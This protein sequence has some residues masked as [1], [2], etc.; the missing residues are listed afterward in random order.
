MYP[1]NYYF[2]FLGKT[3]LPPNYLLY[4]MKKN[5]LF[6]F[7]ILCYAFSYAQ[8]GMDKI[9][10]KLHDDSFWQ[11]PANLET[12]PIRNTTSILGF[13]VK[14]T[15]TVY[16]TG[17]NDA[18]L[19]ANGISFTPGNFRALPVEDILFAP[20]GQPV[21]GNVYFAFPADMDG[22]PSQAL[23]PPFTFPDYKVSI[24]LVFGPKGMDIGTVVTNIP[25]TTFLTFDI[26]NEIQI[27]SINDAIPDIVISQE[28]MTGSND[29]KDEIWFEDGNGNMIGH[30]I[31][32]FIANNTTY[33]QLGQTF[34][35]FYKL[36]NGTP[37][38]NVNSSRY[39]KMFSVKLSDF[40]ITTLNYTQVK[41]LKYKFNGSSDPGVIAYNESSFRI[42][43]LEAVD[44][45]ATTDRETPV[46]INI[47]DN[48]QY[49]STDPPVITF[50][51]SPAHGTI[52]LSG[53]QVIY[54]PDIN[55]PG[56]TVTFNY[57]I[58]DSYGC[59]EA[60]VTITIENV[61]RK[62]PNL[63][64]ADSYTK[65]GITTLNGVQNT[66]P[67]A[68]IPNGFL[69]LESLDKGMVIS[70]TTSASITNPVEGMIIYDTS[71]NCVKLYS[72]DS[73]NVGIW[74]CIKVTCKD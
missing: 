55:F 11:T 16:S 46:T 25:S 38:W 67:E 74:K 24:P 64:P 9:F 58:C 49:D 21:G 18:M 15:G 72:V 8:V 60:L 32:V 66:W 30:R 26:L 45:F 53:N 1:P 62:L 40:G 57:R 39:F 28:A 2:F 22:N 48:D 13:R 3:I 27:N 54:T 34:Y 17:I 4:L 10:L 42:V 36:E 69:A 14:S 12:N 43:T 63:E 5:I 73:S 37:P 23:P 41:Q 56:P 20:Y 7:S 47:L 51:D 29:A 52:T 50:L 31:E 70:R 19:S 68:H 6:V 33:P 65:I 71:D 44:D 35:D 59:E 61:C